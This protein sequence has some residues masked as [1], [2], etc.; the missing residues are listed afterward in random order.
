[1]KHTGTRSVEITEIYS[2]FLQLRASA[3]TYAFVL[4][5][6]SKEDYLW[7]LFFTKSDI[8]YHKKMIEM[9]KLDIFHNRK[10]TYAASKCN[11]TFSLLG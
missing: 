2:F 3:K 11:L 8:D 1:M 7:S 4:F 5:L 9:V 10:S 6:C